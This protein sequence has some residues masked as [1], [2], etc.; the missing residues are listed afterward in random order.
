LKH[1]GKEEAEVIK[2]AGIARDRRYRRN[3]K[4][5]PRICANEHESNKFT[6]FALIRG[7]FL[8]FSIP[9]I[10]AITRGS[11]DLLTLL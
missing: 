6:P 9:A 7:P 11:S 8:V 3:R 2:I 5:L 10:T 1:G 4:S